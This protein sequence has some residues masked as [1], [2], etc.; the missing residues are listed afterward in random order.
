MSNLFDHWGYFKRV[1]IDYITELH[2]SV[3]G[4]SRW[5]I[6]GG[7]ID[8]DGWWMWFITGVAEGHKWESV[9]CGS[10]WETASSGTPVISYVTTLI[11]AQHME[12]TNTPEKTRQGGGLRAVEMEK[13]PISQM[14]KNHCKVHYFDALWE[15]K[16]QLARKYASFVI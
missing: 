8:R 10:V 3:V 14:L 13:V 11:G 6:V 9:C 15:E 7:L 16:R 1:T 12:K 4:P 5:T 2:L